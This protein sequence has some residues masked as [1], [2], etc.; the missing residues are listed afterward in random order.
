MRRRRWPTCSSDSPYYGLNHHPPSTLQKEKSFCLLRLVLLLG[1]LT[2]NKSSS[3]ARETDIEKYISIGIV[4]GVIP[5]P[6]DWPTTTTTTGNWLTYYL[7]I[8]W[9]PPSLV[10]VVNLLYCGWMA[11]EDVI[12]CRRRRHSVYRFTILLRP[13]PSSRESVAKE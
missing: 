1:K 13:H 7:H 3:R 12:H 2:P 10:A 5:G 11:H 6:Q 4:K 8:H 9:D